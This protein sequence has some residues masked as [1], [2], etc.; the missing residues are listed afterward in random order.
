MNVMHVD[1]LVLGLASPCIFLIFL[2]KVGQLG[3][4]SEK[5]KYAEL[6]L[7]L[8]DNLGKDSQPM[9]LPVK[10]EIDILLF[11]KIYDPDRKS[12]V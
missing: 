10:T 11:F 1:G 4:V 7:F 6:K 5:S 3:G 9:P 8:E 12:V 2:L